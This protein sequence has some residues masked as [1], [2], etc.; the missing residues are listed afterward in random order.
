MQQ[1][2]TPLV[3]LG[4]AIFA[5]HEFTCPPVSGDEITDITDVAMLGDKIIVPRR[6]APQ[7]LSFDL[8]G[9]FK[10]NQSLPQVRR[11]FDDFCW[12]TAIQ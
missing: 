11:R 1:A 7:L 9:N 10:K 8:D 2:S 6:S 4:E 3:C 5:A 12:S